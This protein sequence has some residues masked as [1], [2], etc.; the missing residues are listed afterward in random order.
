[1]FQLAVRGCGIGTGGRSVESAAYG[2][3]GSSGAVQRVVRVAIPS[4]SRRE[5]LSKNVM[6]VTLGRTGAG[7]VGRHGEGIA[8]CSRGFWNKF[9]TACSLLWRRMPAVSI[10]LEEGR[11]RFDVTR[12]TFSGLARALRSMTMNNALLGTDVDVATLCSARFGGEIGLEAPAPPLTDSGV[13][14]SALQAFGWQP[15]SCS[16]TRVTC[17]YRVTDTLPLNHNRKAPEAKP[18]VSEQSTYSPMP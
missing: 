1:M 12:V 3:S 10:M 2:V 16:V 6:R 4:P 5:V 14:W 13:C 9:V 11:Q 17:P 15:A 18:G 8:R 7:T